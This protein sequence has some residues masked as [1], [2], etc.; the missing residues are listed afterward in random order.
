MSAEPREELI[1]FQAI[2]N[3]GKESDEVFGGT[4]AA[5]HG[6][7]VMSIVVQGCRF[8]LFVCLFCYVLLFGCLVFRLS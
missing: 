2:E 7:Q 6:Y 1:D 5:A 8:C 3:D 4:E